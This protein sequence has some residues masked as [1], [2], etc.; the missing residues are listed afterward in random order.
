MKYKNRTNRRLFLQLPL[1]GFETGF[2]ALLHAVGG[3]GGAADGIHILAEG[4]VDGGNKY[5]QRYIALY[6]VEE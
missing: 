3:V 1:I 6:T 5:K 2:E 4:F